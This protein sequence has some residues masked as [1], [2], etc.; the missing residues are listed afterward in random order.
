MAEHEKIAVVPAGAFGT[1]MGI[2]AS[3]N[4]HDVALYIPRK[5]TL[6]AIYKT[7]QNPRLPGVELTNAI[8]ATDDLAEALSG[9]DIVVFSAPSH[10]AKR[11][12][13]QVADVAEKGQK[14]LSLTKGFHIDRAG[15][16][17]VFTDMLRSF[18]P[19][20]RTAALS[21]PNFAKIVA[22]GK[23]TVRTVIASADD[24]GVTHQAVF[25][26]DRLL[27]LLDEDEVGVQSAGA[28]KNVLSLGTGMCEGAGVHRD[29]LRR[30]IAGGPSEMAMLGKVLGAKRET[31]DGVAGKGD[32][33][34]TCTTGSRNYRAGIALGEG[35]V[36]PGD[37]LKRAIIG[38][39]MVE[40]VHAAWAVKLL[41]EKHNL[42]L[43]VMGAVVDVL[44]SGMEPDEAVRR[45]TRTI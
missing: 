32:L 28:A 22:D 29:T 2:V 38:K 39:E 10:M 37:L 19:D 14:V 3:R 6:L 24:T 5:E 43:P 45:I 21:G 41:S 34:L 7:R 15:E 44:Y 40:G 1:A 31:F 35:K 23:E 20:I 17:M 42:D 30:I 8:R 33:E 9:R 25:A 13:E 27:I 36:G 18:A 26:T 16:V 11:F 4:G 12:G